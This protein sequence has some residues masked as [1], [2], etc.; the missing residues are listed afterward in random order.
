MVIVPK[1]ACLEGQI[2]TVQHQFI[3]SQ[4]KLEIAAGRQEPSP[5]L[6]CTLF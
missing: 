2:F 4:K 1:T 3:K 5:Q 6:L